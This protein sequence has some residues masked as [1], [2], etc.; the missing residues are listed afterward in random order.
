MQHNEDHIVSDAVEEDRKEAIGTHGSASS[1]GDDVEA[2]KDNNVQRPQ[3]L[4]EEKHDVN[5]GLGDGSEK[6]S[7]IVQAQS[8]LVADEPPDGGY[9]A[10][11][12]VVGG[13]CGMFVSFGWTNCMGIF[14]DYYQTHQLSHESTSTITWVTSLMTFMMFFGG[15]FIGILF[16]NFGP[17]YIILAGTLLHVFGIMMTSISTE[18]YQFLLAQGICSPIGTSALFH[19]G[20]NSIS[21]WFRHRRALAL[22]IAT[23]GASLGGVILPIM[24]TRLFHQLGF[25]WAM[26]I[27]A[28]LILFLLIITNLTTKS[29]LVHR[30]KRF[31]LMDFIRPLGELPFV[32]TTAGTFCF[33][34][35]MFLPFSFI[36][37]QAERYGMSATLAS[38]MIPVLNA[39]RFHPG[40]IIPPYLADLFGRFNLM[41]LTT[42]FSG[43]IVLAIWLPTRGN[44]PAIVFSALYGFSS[45]TVVSLAPA[46]VAQ[47]SE[48]REIGVRSGTYFFIVS[49]AALTGTPIAGA[50][51][52]DPL[53]GSY[54]KLYIFCAVVMFAGAGFYLLAKIDR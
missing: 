2:N 11:M 27:C 51:L 35:G 6:S 26:R 38:Y 19:A 48:I 3:P 22:G 30:R 20:I 7:T 42:L 8:T 39:A 14:L 50:L 45:G 52:P 36:P 49:F 4:E 23:S 40:R 5:G 41:I 17:R 43:I 32:L 21:T 28:F 53:H 9:E 1:T 37:S 31:H 10:W 12:T 33:F 25:G 34:W 15:P 18:Y 54:T 44:A 16:D 24:L 13:F 47:I 46:L 29:R